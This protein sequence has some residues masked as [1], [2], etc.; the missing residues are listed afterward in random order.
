MPDHSRLVGE[1]D[2]F[3]HA[4]VADDAL[5]CA[6]GLDSGVEKSSPQADCF[7]LSTGDRAENQRSLRDDS[8]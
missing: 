7:P 1:G 5:R 8:I 6:R 2:G 3:Y 4:A